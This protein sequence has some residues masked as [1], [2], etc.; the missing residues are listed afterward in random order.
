MKKTHLPRP[1]ASFVTRCG[2]SAQW[3]TNRNI[4]KVIGRATCRQCVNNVAVVGT[5]EIRKANNEVFKA[6][7][8]LR[9][10]G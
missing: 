5:R 2:R 10:L 6:A 8:R 9:E 7:C 1:G 3:G 4:T